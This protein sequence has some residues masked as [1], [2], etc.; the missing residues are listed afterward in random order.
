MMQSI[1]R[2]DVVR[3]I[4]AALL[5]VGLALFGS[6]ASAAA[7]PAASERL[8]APWLLA[9]AQCTRRVGT[10]A[11]NDRAFAVRNQLVSQGYRAWIETHGALYEGTRTY[12]VFVAVC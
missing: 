6:A 8:G 10:Y 11:T 12:V 1:R 3:L 7:P 5:L 4:L 9:Q 2:H